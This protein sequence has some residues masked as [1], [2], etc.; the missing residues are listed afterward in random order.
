MLFVLTI[1]S[2]GIRPAGAK[3]TRARCA[4]FRSRVRSLRMGAIFNSKILEGTI[5]T[6]VGAGK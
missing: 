5:T 3:Y 2:I 1:R 4:R 6:G